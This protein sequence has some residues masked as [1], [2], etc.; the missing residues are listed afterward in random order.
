MAKSNTRKTE[1]TPGFTTHEGAPA[2]KQSAL[3]ELTRAV[4]SC[5][6]FEDTFY[7]DGNSLAERIGELVARAPLTDV[8]QLA[9]KARTDLKLRHVPL[10]LCVQMLKHPDKRVPALANMVGDTIEKVIQRADELAEIWAI[11]RKC[12]G[13]SEPRQLKAG[14]A[15]AFRKFSAYELAKYN[16]ADATVKLRDAL[17]MSHAKPKDKAQAK[18]WKQLI[19]GTLA[20]PDTWEVALSAGADKKETFTRLLK[21]EKLGYMALLRNLRNMDEAGVN[22][23][24]VEDQLIERSKG[25]KALP[26]RFVAA[27]RFA[28]SY[29]EALDKAMMGSIDRSVELEG[30]T[31]I[32]LDVSGSM[33]SPISEKSKI[34][35][36][37]AG[38]A[39]ACLLRE[40][41]TTV[42][43]F[44][45]GT[46]CK[47]VPNY[48]G[49]A[50][51]DNI[52][53][54]QG[55]DHGTNVGNAV[56]T[57][58][59]KYPDVKRIFVV[60]D[61][62]SGDAVPSIGNDRR[63]YYINVRPYAPALPTNGG[64]WTEISGF[65]E[66]IIDWVRMEE[67]ST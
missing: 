64:Q 41:C 44:Q 4:S 28:P 32:A 57:I 7:E 54:N 63:G 52:T 25:S 39:L 67:S 1:V 34:A 8:A 33:D 10:F 66:R 19:D 35:A 13:K 49:L 36:K 21:E 9:I 45:F 16:R 12:G 50:L 47:E 60:T 5:M 30:E 51:V 14:V 23:K 6:L 55:V 37:D 3:N 56:L 48:R 42:R 29:A 18:I 58:I 38:G 65:S 11:Y 62:Q 24:L 17:F 26:F 27:A 61:M 59:R 40:I 2:V 53:Q 31:A 20:S 46:R 15:K 22:R 43:M